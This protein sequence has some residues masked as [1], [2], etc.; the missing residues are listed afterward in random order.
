MQLFDPH[1]V[2]PAYPAQTL[3]A[4]GLKV[5]VL[6]GVIDAFHRCF[7][8]TM[9]SAVALELLTDQRMTP[10]T[11]PGCRRG[12]RFDPGLAAGSQRR[13]KGR[14]VAGGVPEDD[15]RGGG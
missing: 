14:G 12:S 7:G 8:P 15:K 4:L 2:T 3:D 11:P 6:A 13:G 5:L 9:M 1:P 10:A